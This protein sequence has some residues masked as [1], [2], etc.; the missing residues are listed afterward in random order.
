MINLEPKKK[1]REIW[2][3]IFLCFFAF[4]FVSLI[5]YHP[6]DPSL[7]SVSST[8]EI[9]NLSGMTGAYVADILFQTFGVSAFIILFPILLI[10]SGC[11]FPGWIGRKF[12][13]LF[14]F[15]LLMFFLSGFSALSLKTIVI[16]D[17]KLLAGGMVGHLFSSF[18]LPYFN[19]TGSY[20]LILGGLLITLIL[21]LNLSVATLLKVFGVTG[22]KILSIFSLFRGISIPT[23]KKKSPPIPSFK[24]PQRKPISQEP[25]LIDDF[26]EDPII[27]KVPPPPPTIKGGPIEFIDDTPT[28]SD[29]PPL[30]IEKTEKKKDTSS[31]KFLGDFLKPKGNFKFPEISLLSDPPKE[32]IQI[33]KESLIK[34]SR[35]L[36]Q[37][38]RDFNIEG[39]VVE[40]R[41]GPIITVYE[42]EP[43][44]GIK[45]SKIVNLA[46]DLSL[47]RK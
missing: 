20:I 46:D 39:R 33:D 28:T 14:G 32:N 11:F 25:I 1:R 36:E 15:A 8:K 9:Q 12:V 30:I 45:V 4:V 29:R 43:A 26:E 34:N 24:E 5:S 16:H 3:V 19:L 2:G 13:K 17:Q 44:P 42:F 41:P 40:V 38:L 35:I 31:P 37:K 7:N 10:M 22:L 47:D 23:F 21:S 27:E 18:F 6:L